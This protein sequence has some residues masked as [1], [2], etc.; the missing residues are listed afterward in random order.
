MTIPGFPGA[1]SVSSL[2]VYDGVAP[3]G[4]AGGTP[5]LHLVSAEAYLVVAGLGR[6]HTID[7]AG[8]FEERALAPGDLVWFA[9]G[10]IHRAINDGGLEVRVIMQNA[11]LPEAGDAVMTFPD[12]VLAD[13]GRYADAARLPGAAASDA[14][15][16]AAAHARRDLA[17]EGYLALF[18]DVGDGTV[19]ADR[20]ARLHARAAELARPR[21]ADWRARWEAGALAVARETGHRLDALASGGDPGLGEARVAEASVAPAFGMC[22]RLQRYDTTIDPDIDPLGGAR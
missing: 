13:A 14:D 19:D 16:L 15:R 3:D 7:G 18:R 10:V 4:L 2:E 11:G 12:D 6:L 8:A 17:V 9:P 21:V 1:T 5:H 22:G 20:L